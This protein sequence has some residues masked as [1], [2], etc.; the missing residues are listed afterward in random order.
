MTAGQK[1]TAFRRF[2]TGSAGGTG[3]G[4]AIV[5]RLVVSGGGT[6]TLSDTDGGGLTVTILLP[7]ATRSRPAPGPRWATAGGDLAGPGDGTGC[8]R[9][10]FT[11]SERFLNRTRASGRAS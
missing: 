6:A 4:L 7:A 3:L 2:A 10:A 11:G 1:R 9:P 8:Q 5:D